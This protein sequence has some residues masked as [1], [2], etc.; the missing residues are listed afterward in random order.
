M[1]GFS[2]TGTFIA[3]LS[4]S[5]TSTR[6]CGA[7]V[8]C[9]SRSSV[10]GGG[11]FIAI[12]ESPI[13]VLDPVGVYIPAARDFYATQLFLAAQEA[14]A[15]EAALRARLI[16]N[17]NLL[18]I[19]QIAEQ[20]GDVKVAGRLYQRVALSRPRTEVTTTA[21]QRLSQIQGAALSKLQ[22]IEDQLNAI[23]K[24]GNPVALQK[25]KV[26][27]AQ[28]ASLFDELDKLVLEYAGV[29]SIE[30]RLQERIDR[31]R[32]Q[33][34]FAAI[35]QEPVASEL[36]KVAQKHEDA[37][38]LCCAFLAYE[39]AAD[40]APAPSGE[41]ARARLARLKADS[42]IVEA[43]RN[44]RNLQTCHDKYRRALAIKA[45]LPDKARAYF[46]DIIE[47]APPDTSVHKAAREQIAMLR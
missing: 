20:G 38:Q 5:L 10:A 44:C 1:R 19:A 22:S 27:V 18:S 15:R 30:N 11:A 39:Q 43:A 7:E 32:R 12:D 8:V 28:V 33:K 40:L 41:A 21:G 34:Q 45:T 25:A 2:T 23:V 42:S 9:A 35:L 36:L 29:D 24:S 47:L 3:L 31:L 26:D 14:A 37:Q 17:Q 16:R 4:I 13:I 6:A 46:S